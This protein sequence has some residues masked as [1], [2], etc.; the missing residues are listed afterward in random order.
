MPIAIPVV[1][2]A[3]GTGAATAAT[4]TAIGAA[5]W[6]EVLM[7]ALI[8]AAVGALSV[9]LNM[10]F[11]PR[12]KG[13]PK[14]KGDEVEITTYTRTGRIPVLYGTRPLG[15]NVIMLGLVE[16]RQINREDELPEQHLFGELVGAITE[17]PAAETIALY[18]DDEWQ[19]L[20]KW[21][22]TPGDGEESPFPFFEPFASGGVNPHHKWVAKVHVHGDMGN[23]NDIP[24]MT[25]DQRGRYPDIQV[26][27]SVAVG[28]VPSMG[29]VDGLGHEI[30]IRPLNPPAGREDGLMTLGIPLE[31]GATVEPQYAEFPVAGVQ[32]AWRVGLVGVVVC[33]DPV[34][35]TKMYFA[36]ANATAS[37]WES[38]TLPA[39]YEQPIE[40]AFLDDRTS[41][42]HT[43]HRRDDR[44]YIRVLSILTL[45]A[46]QFV[47]PSAVPIED[48]RA[49]SFKPEDNRYYFVIGGEL[50]T[51][52]A[53]DL[54]VSEWTD[55]ARIEDPDVVGIVKLGIY[56]WLFYERTVVQ[57]DVSTGEVGETLPLSDFIDQAEFDRLGGSARFVNVG[58]SAAYYM[59][60]AL[61]RNDLDQWTIAGFYGPRDFGE[62][63][64]RRVQ[65]RRYAAWGGAP[66]RRIPKPG[67]DLD[68]PFNQQTWITIGLP[69]AAKSP[70]AMISEGADY[71]T[72]GPDI[73]DQFTLT[74]D[75]GVVSFTA[76]M[77]GGVRLPGQNRSLRVIYIVDPDSVNL[78]V[79]RFW[80]IIAPHFFTA[81][82]E[83]WSETPSYEVVTPESM[84]FVRNM[85]NNLVIQT[86]TYMIRGPMTADNTTGFP[87]GLPAGD[88]RRLPQPTAMDGSPLMM[89]TLFQFGTAM[90][91]RAPAWYPPQTSGW[92]TTPGQL[93]AKL[94]S[95]DIVAGTAN[96]VAIFPKDCPLQ[97]FILTEESGEKAARLIA[98]AC[99]EPDADDLIVYSNRATVGGLDVN[100]TAYQVA[101]AAEW[102]SWNG[103]TIVS[104]RDDKAATTALRLNEAGLRHRWFEGFV[105]PSSECV[106]MLMNTRYGAGRSVDRLIMHEWFSLHGYSL[107]FCRTDDQVIR[108]YLWNHPVITEQ[109]IHD[110]LDTVLGP[111]MAYNLSGDGFFG[112][113][114]ENSSIQPVMEFDASLIEA[115]SFVVAPKSLRTMANR[116][117]VKF[118]NA[119]DGR[120]DQAVENDPEDQEI[121]GIRERDVDLDTITN[122]YRARFVARNMLES[123]QTDRQVFRWNTGTFASILAP[124]MPVLVTHPKGHFSRKPVRIITV[125]DQGNKVAIEA[126]EISPFTVDSAR[127]SSLRNPI[128]RTTAGTIAP[129]SSIRDVSIEQFH[130]EALMPFRSVAAERSGELFLLG[131]R[132]PRSQVTSEVGATIVP[133]LGAGFDLLSTSPCRSVALPV[134]VNSVTQT[135]TY[136]GLYTGSITP[137][138]P[139]RGVL[140]KRRAVGIAADVELCEVSTFTNPVDTADPSATGSVSISRT[141]ADALEV[142]EANAAKVYLCTE[143]TDDI[144]DL[145][146]TGADGRE[147]DAIH[148]K[149]P[150]SWE[151]VT[152]AMA[153]GGSPTPVFTVRRDFV[154]IGID[155]EFVPNSLRIELGTA[156]SADQ[157]LVFEY[158]T[159]LD[160]D[161]PLG[162]WKP[163]AVLDGTRG[164]T[165]SGRVHFEIPP[166][167]AATVTWD[168]HGNTIAR[169]STQPSRLWIRIQRRATSNGNATI[170]TITLENLPVL[171]LVP[172]GAQRVTLPLASAGRLLASRFSARSLFPARL[173]T[174][175]PGNSFVSTGGLESL[176]TVTFVKASVN[177]TETELSQNNSFAMTAGFDVTISF[178]YASSVVGWGRVALGTEGYGLASDLTI[179]GA[180][181]AI[182]RVSDG[183]TLRTKTVSCPDESFTYTNTERVADGNVDVYFR[184]QQ[185][186]SDASNANVFQ[187][188]GDV[189]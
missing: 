46:Q 100:G 167:W 94:Q 150:G 41:R 112:V 96:I 40:F 140:L 71:K 137:P 109:K 4:T 81:Q 80:Q 168:R 89:A 63:Y 50:P 184:I 135:I 139:C 106:D 10:A 165:Q 124:G 116:V 189:P 114:F 23:R 9:A 66:G 136:T 123:P 169:L 79:W 18:F 154:V 159:N 186:G 83:P 78:G 64:M 183:A 74:S 16:F 44:W 107:E 115:G 43:L 118:W 162:V 121:T 56:M 144:N 155:A 164:L 173:I 176:G 20:S 91:H 177:G 58:Q 48:V 72:T 117:R 101:L 3:V 180:T 127:F 142:E 13:A 111:A 62:P 17:G 45:D 21:T 39:A 34:N 152:V 69:D 5:F 53:Y 11:A 131:S 105:T 86:G 28:C 172:L 42:L 6:S 59:G 99:K 47:I 24:N 122:P 75:A 32:W 12:A 31:D 87:L 73:D 51:V 61:V 157:G 25:V 145:E 26:A 54:T 67:L 76:L 36:D 130:G 132:A 170:D 166:T 182:I 129:R 93:I 102:A 125:E 8:G 27:S 119:V 108:R 29:A 60:T 147:I 149:N 97:Q 77:Q 158:S 179:L 171:C 133:T 128:I 68:T 98:A 188:I 163:L 33:Q 113:A 65:F 37:E 153:A 175:C 141:T 160:V 174:E 30:W 120:D 185:V 181:I 148:W 146:P 143:D 35:L 84:S 134:D 52:S 156:A 19:P 88:R 187:C 2:G 104:A 70:A 95:G 1:I 90:G 55:I 178:K 82:S 138:M 161:N 103:S 38:F 22:S 92:T 57:V 7:S 85:F 15:I 110:F 126:Q 151:E 49:F 14:A